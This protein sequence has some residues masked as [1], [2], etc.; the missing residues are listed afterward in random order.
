VF[1]LL[2]LLTVKCHHCSLVCKS[3]VLIISFKIDT[4]HTHW[5]MQN[6]I[7]LNLKINLI[8]LVFNVLDKNLVSAVGI[9]KDTI[10]T[11]VLWIKLIQR[12]FTV[13]NNCNNSM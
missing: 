9:L 10:R 11:Q 4:P 3:F 5:R 2:L 6:Y 7:T 1:L 12:H 8:I 13:T